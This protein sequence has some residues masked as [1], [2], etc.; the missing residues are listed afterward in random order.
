MRKAQIRRETAETKIELDLNLDGRGETEIST[1]VGFL[2]HMLTLFGRHGGFDLRAKCVGDTQVDDHHS[3]ED[4][5]ICLGM[6]FDRALG[7]RRGIRRYGSM[8]LPM[9]EALALVAVDISG[10]AML[11]LDAQFP[12]EKIGAFD[13]QLVGEFLTAF[14]RLAGVT[15]HVRM[16][17]GE[18]SPHIAEAVFKALARALSQACAI[19]P[20][21]AGEIPST[22]GVL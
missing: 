14:A 17:D 18:N 4:V 15:L 21:R 7:D 16:L 11:R 20:A 12:T 2:D 13:T 1:G 19:D 10:R 6:A 22:K 9:D 3:V 5:G 8:L